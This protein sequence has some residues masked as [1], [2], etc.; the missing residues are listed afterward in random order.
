[1]GLFNYIKVE[2][3]LPL[4]ATLKVLNHNWRDEEYQ[5]K[6]LEDNVMAIYILRDNKLFEEI[7][8]GHHE[9]KS[10]EELEEDKK[11]YGKRFAPI[12]TDKFIVDK[13]YEKF[14][15]DYT[16]T[17]VFGCIVN[18]DNID[19]TDFY[20]DWKAVVV[21]G[22]VKELT[23]LPEYTKFSSKDRIENQRKFDEE[24]E[25]HRRKMKCPVY[26]FYYTYYVQVVEKFSWK[27]QRLIS[28]VIRGLDWINW[29]GVRF[30]VKV[31]TPR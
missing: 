7:T 6:E 13:K 3:E 17:F 31:L 21:E 22:I 24:L 5:T 30:L 20:P 14:R 25:T 23:M 12:W 4:D 9:P 26:K 16:G 29:R 10:K 8:E 2:Q 27:V 15:D 1:M 11:I 18:S 28:K 19:G